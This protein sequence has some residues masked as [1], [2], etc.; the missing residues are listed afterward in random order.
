QEAGPAP[1]SFLL[2]PPRPA[3]GGGGPLGGRFLAGRG[4]LW[5][6]RVGAGGGGGAGGRSGGFWVVVHLLPP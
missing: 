5:G 2:G 4:G 1:L 6:G 3:V